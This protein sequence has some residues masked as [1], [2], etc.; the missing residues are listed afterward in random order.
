MSEQQNVGACPDLEMLGAFFE[1]HGGGQLDQHIATCSSCLDRLEKLR[2]DQFHNAATPIHDV[3]KFLNG[4]EFPPF[5]QKILDLVST[6]PPAEPPL[7]P[8][9][10][11]RFQVC[12]WLGRGTFGDVYAAFDPLLKINV[13]IK[14]SRSGL[15][16]ST[17]S[18]ADFLLEAQR[19]ARLNHPGLVHIRDVIIDDDRTAIVMNLVDG[20]TL[21]DRLKSA[22][23]SP[24]ALEDAVGM[25]T[26]IARAAHFAH[27]AGLIHRDLKPANILLEADGRPV[28][29]DFGLAFD[30]REQS[31]DSIHQAGT[32]P[33]MPP[34]QYGPPSSIDRRSDLW[35]MGVILAE[36]I[37]GERPFLQKT[38]PELERAIREDP[39]KLPDV[40][41]KRPLNTIIKKCLAKSPADRYATADEFAHNLEQWHRKYTATGISRWG[42]R[43]HVALAASALSILVIFFLAQRQF[44]EIQLSQTTANLEAATAS[45]I[46]RLVNE[47]RLM[48]ASPYFLKGRS[49]TSDDDGRFRLNL[50]RGACGDNDP[51]LCRDIVNYLRSAKLEE[52]KAASMP[53]VCDSIRDGLLT[54]TRR[55]LD[56]MLSAREFLRLAAIVAHFGSDDTVWSSLGDR[57]AE[58]LC[59]EVPNN[60]LDDWK[61]IFHPIG[62]RSLGK[63]LKTLMTLPESSE[64]IQHRSLTLLCSFFR[65]DIDQLTEL[66]RF[67]DGKKMIPLI[68]V[69]N[70]HPESFRDQA[71]E[72]LLETFQRLNR[73]PRNP[74]PDDDDPPTEQDLQS[75]RV[76]V[77]LWELGDTRAAC[78]ALRDDPNPTLKRLVI[79][80]LKEQSIS[81]TSLIKKIDDLRQTGAPE[82]N[83]IVFGLL[84]TLWL[85]DNHVVGNKICPHW[86]NE[87]YFDE[88][89]GIHSMG[90]LLAKRFSVNL[91]PLTEGIHGEWCVDRFEEITMEFRV[92]EKKREFLAGRP[93]LHSKVFGLDSWRP[94]KR[95]I[96][97]RFAIGLHEVT[98]EQ[99]R[100][101]TAAARRRKEIVAGDAAATHLGDA[102]IQDVFHF[103]NWCSEMN[104]LDAC[105]EPDPL[106]A[107]GRYL[108]PRKDYL[109]RSGYRLPTDGEWECACRAGTETSCFFGQLPTD[110]DFARALI[111]KY[112]WMFFTPGKLTI[113]I[114]QGQILSQPVGGKL[115]NRWGLFDTYGNVM[116]LC[117]RSSSP[118]DGTHEI[119]MMDSV[120]R[121]DEFENSFE[122]C[123]RGAGL[124]HN[125]I[126]YVRSHARTEKVRY[127]PMSGIRIAKTL[128][129]H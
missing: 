83:G 92:I 112:A 46:P 67:A 27:E 90:A 12:R 35:A 32:L 5:Q 79:F 111:N 117:V 120:V 50:A 17:S 64:T 4:P 81:P 124:N 62:A 1:G 110:E 19:I 26:Q 57:V 84:Q 11:N 31:S 63:R 56:D 126:A 41:T 78:L 114:A 113:P 58:E 22:E 40:P 72:S 13:A 37:H 85:T 75:A 123:I 101:T 49:V 109:L 10:I 29:A 3:E 6:V 71:R 87:I 66:I 43:R 104:R 95:I 34:E 51:Q 68:D 107:E 115:P 38:R 118:E 21:K 100:K 69:I 105:Y 121:S 65:D 96:D 54:S 128:V 61:E 55:C 59:S 129:S 127:S 93:N 23:N 30:H 74:S 44:R 91:D 48:G 53:G 70:R 2:E 86:L 99:I 39:P 52:L 89:S 45:Q 24:L 80:G 25:M 106:R 9:R 108:V 33:Y 76:A 116:E 122:T 16:S 82:S 102:E 14:V 20:G 94:H 103:C 42:W 98:W 7:L 73:E 77:V 97:Y 88:D 8:D 18:Q 125:Q 119:K 47:L 15:F 28:I 36:M 60:E